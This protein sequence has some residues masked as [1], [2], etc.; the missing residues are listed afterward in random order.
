MKK[1]QDQAILNRA[2]QFD[3]QALEEIYDLYSPGIYRYAYRLLGDVDLA[4]DCMSETFSRF[5]TAL[6][7][8]NGPDN[9]IQAYLY[10]IA[11]NWVTDF[12]RSKA[13]TTLPLDMDLRAD[14][15]DEPQ[16]KTAASLEVQQ[17]RKALSQLTP[18]QRQVIILRYLEELENET[19]AQV[20]NKPVGSIKALQHRGL[21]SLRRI[22]IRFEDRKL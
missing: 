11:H 15:I 10:R 18:S 22:L 13:S 8:G 14:E 17:L 5:L 1:K 4:M 6:R 16:I 3:R 12:Y 20:M 9:Y 2:K 19:I 7:H 21:E